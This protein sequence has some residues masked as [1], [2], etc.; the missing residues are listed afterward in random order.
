MTIEDCI[1]G[2]HAYVSRQHT[3]PYPGKPDIHILV[4]SC[5]HCG[6]VQPVHPERLSWQE[7]EWVRR[8][9]LNCERWAIITC[10]AKPDPLPTNT[11]PDSWFKWDVDTS[12]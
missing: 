11:Y 7:K 12:R 2:N 9:N 8:W 3:G 1:Q 10:N 6:A 5:A 4:D